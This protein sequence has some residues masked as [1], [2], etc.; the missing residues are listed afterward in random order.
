MKARNGLRWMPAL[1]AAL[2]L[3]GLTATP[4]VAQ[5]T[6]R[7]QGTVVNGATQ[8]ALSGAQVFVDGTNIGSLTNSE[9]S[10][11]LLNVPAGTHTVRVQM[12]G[13]GGGEQQVVVAAGE[14]ATADFELSQTAVALEQVVVTGTATEVRR[15]EIGNSLE[16]ITSSQIETAP[17]E[18]AQE[19]LAARAPGVTYMRN[20]GQPGAGGTIKI[21]GI[22]TVSQNMEPLIYVDGVR[23]FH[24]STQDRKSV[25]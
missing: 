22:T 10:Y 2:A 14:L 23:I 7:V 6:G 17:V 16:A 20:S 24:E 5:Q 9:G 8:Q 21:R 11:L 18:N 1:L 15:R 12:I 13:Y 4:G 3:F 25:V 19:A